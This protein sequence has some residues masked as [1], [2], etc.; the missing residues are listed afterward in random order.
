L[1]ICGKGFDEATILRVGYAYEQAT[2][3]HDRIP[4]RAWVS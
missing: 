3:W 2:T 4:E 1:M